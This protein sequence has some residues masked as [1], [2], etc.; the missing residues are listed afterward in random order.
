[1]DT[2]G[3]TPWGD[4]SPGGKQLPPGGSRGLAEPS[5]PPRP[6]QPPS[7]AGTPL[8]I[9]PA[10]CHGV[11]KVLRSPFN[12]V[13]NL[14]GRTQSPSTPIPSYGTAQGPVP[15]PSPP[16]PPRAALSR[17]SGRVR[18]GAERRRRLPSGVESAPEIA[19]HLRRLPSA[20]G[21]CRAG[22]ALPFPP[23]GRGRSGS[24]R[25]AAHG[26]AAPEA[27]PAE[28]AARPRRGREEEAEAAGLRWKRE[29][30]GHTAGTRACV[31]V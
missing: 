19:E 28:G 30:R 27:E 23:P 5:S 22:A 16:S 6:P 10:P 14:R 1:M 29:G 17:R 7:S 2:M 8:K 13:A 26:A 31:C 4:T 20:A 12:P 9:P 11:A 3:W 21:D 25:G 24:G 15:P 18:G